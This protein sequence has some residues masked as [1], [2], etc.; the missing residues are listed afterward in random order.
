MRI[1]LL[2]CLLGTLLVPGAYAAGVTFDGETE[3]EAS[4][5]A[6]VSFHIDVSDLAPGD[7][8]GLA[9]EVAGSG[10]PPMVEEQVPTGVQPTQR[11]LRVLA[12]GTYVAQLDCR[13]AGGAHHVAFLTATSDDPPPPDPVDGACG[14]AHG[15]SVPAMPTGADACAAGNRDVID[16]GED[17]G[18]YEW[19]C[20]GMDGGTDAY[21]MA[22]VETAPPP[23]PGEAASYTGNRS[24]WLSQTD[25]LDWDFPHAQSCVAS[26]DW[27]GTKAPT[28]TYSV[29]RF[30]AGTRTYTLSCSNAAGL[31]T[32]TVT[33]P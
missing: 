33:L 7:D 4:V 14:A 10:V 3:A 30:L 23:D 27:S 22:V 5:G 6:V 32:R 12:P 25:T 15:T 28:G 20:R 8:C 17:S 24:G 13:A 26:G 21:C 19:A 9:L 31:A 29:T 2:F 16:T 18:L 1:P 11:A